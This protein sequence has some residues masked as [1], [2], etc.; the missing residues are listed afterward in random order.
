MT[1][2][3]KKLVAE[4]IQATA[5]ALTAQLTVRA[6]REKDP[7]RFLFDAL[8]RLN[9]LSPADGSLD[10]VEQGLCTFATEFGLTVPASAGQSEAAL[11]N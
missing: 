11:M 4:Q 6:A 8:C 1:P 10:A 3:I 7:Q 2:E 5:K 9:E